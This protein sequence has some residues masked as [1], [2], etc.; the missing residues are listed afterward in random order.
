MNARLVRAIARNVGFVCVAIVLV[1]CVIHAFDP[2]RLNWGDSMSDYNVMTSGRNFWRYGFVN[3]R[4]TPILLD[5]HYLT[6]L[7]RA[8]I[9]THYPQLPDLLNGVERNLGLSTL[10]QFRFVALAFSFCALVWIYRLVAMYW[11]RAVAQVAL[12]LWVINPMWIQ[13]ADYLH[14]A[15]LGAFFGF[16]SVYF[17]ARY[18]RDAAPRRYLIGSGV[19]L[20]FAMLASYD[21]WFFAPL[22]L[23]F[24]AFEAR[25]VGA[26]RAIRLLALLGVFGAGA[27]AF[28]FGTN[29]WALGGVGAML[30]DMRFQYVERATD[31]ITR[32][33]FQ[34]G[35]FVVMF[36]RIARFFTVLLFATLALWL[37]YP[38]FRRRLAARYRSLASVGPNPLFLLAAA[39]P[40]LLMF[41][42]IWMGQYYPTLLL[43]PFYAVGIAIPIVLLLGADRRAYRMLGAAVLF[44]LFANSASEDILFPKA[45]LPVSTIRELRAQLDSVSAPGQQILVDHVFDAAYRYYFD[46]NSN[47]VILMPPKFVQASLSA[48][49]DPKR[50][51]RS[52][53][54]VGAIFVHD[55]HLTTDLYDKGYYY[56]LGRYG[57]WEL[58]ADPSRYRSAIDSI[59][60]LRDS[61]L[62][63]A[64][65][66]DGTRLYDTKDYSIWRV[67]PQQ[68]RAGTGAQALRN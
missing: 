33:T 53:T 36:W 54:P 50:H 29:A 21:Y 12:G 16:G 26:G 49:A 1:Y 62:M 61:V 58:W 18:L 66:E 40:F 38:A 43:L 17:F 6:P 31:A 68:T 55:K 25:R 47:A 65:V 9:Y 14:H 24:V 22:L 48:L 13:H 37:A 15:P 52:G 44:G 42:E 4:F 28:K 39:L 56:L 3:L 67:N 59:V 45:F 23:A 32:T 57:F 11:S 10:T 2:P 46:R 64:V 35:L 51:P 63:A 19:F 5:L 30:R 27:L 8:M 60:Q 34:Q 20:F 7:D 41:K